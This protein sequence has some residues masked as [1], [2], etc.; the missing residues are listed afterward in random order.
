MLTLCP[1]ESATIPVVYGQL[2]TLFGI[3]CVTVRGQAQMPVAIAVERLSLT[4]RI[5]TQAGHPGG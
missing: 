5:G 3:L 1:E 4:G 2:G